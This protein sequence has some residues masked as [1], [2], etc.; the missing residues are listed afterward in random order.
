[1]EDSRCPEPSAVSVCVFA[2]EEE[3]ERGVISS[4]FFPQCCFI[5]RLLEGQRPRVQPKFTEAAFTLAADGCRAWLSSPTSM[6]QTRHLSA[7][8]DSSA[9]TTDINNNNKQFLLSRK[10]VG[11]IISVFMETK[12]HL[13]PF[14]VKV[15][16][17]TFA[18]SRLA[19]ALTF[20]S[21]VLRCC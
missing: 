6:R 15:L 2:G 16:L 5:A 8:G 11:P 13:L 21:C 7:Y 18:G 10:H 9:S 17:V 12:S 1:M 20:E 19:P 14:E 4:T 3:G